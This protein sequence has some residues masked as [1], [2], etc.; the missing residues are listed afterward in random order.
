MNADEIVVNLIRLNGRQIDCERLQWEA[1]L[2][3]R[4]G[5]EFD[6]KFIYHHGGPYSHDLAS[7]W[8][9]AR[10]DRRI[11]VKESKTRHGTPYW[12]SCRSD[13]DKDRGSIN[14][15]ADDEARR[16]LEKMATASD[17]ALELAS[18]L[19][20]LQKEGEYDA[21][22]AEELKIRKPLT[23]R[24]EKLVDEARRLLSDLGLETAEA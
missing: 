23:T 17:L 20:F 15:L 5:A 14:G 2:L 18:A 11:A 7:G 12:V 3:H 1:Y 8:E 6:V 9:S 24:N 21:H 19:V 13:D 10:Y 16:W 4:C 22:A